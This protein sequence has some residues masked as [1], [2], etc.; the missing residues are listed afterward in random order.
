VQASEEARAA[1]VEAKQEVFE[2]RQVRKQRIALKYDA[3]VRTRLLRQRLPVD[4]ELSSTRRLDTQQ[5]AQKSG[6][7]AAGCADDRD[8]FVVT[9][10]QVHI[11]EDNLGLIFFP[12]SFDCNL[13]HDYR[14][15]SAHGKALARNNRSNA[16]MVKASNVI[17]AT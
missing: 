10:V 17:Q 12:E 6:L 9:D 4:Q 5:H 14:P 15:D 11:L 1:E 13:S 3:A 16:S 8:E 7:A 2:H